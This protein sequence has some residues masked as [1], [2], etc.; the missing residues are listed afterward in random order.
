MKRC[1]PREWWSA[2]A[3]SGKHDTE[4]FGFINSKSLSPGVEQRSRCSA[5]RVR[6]VMVKTVLCYRL[7][8]CK[9]Q[10]GKEMQRRVEPTA[11]GIRH[12]RKDAVMQEK[13]S[14]TR[15]SHEE[16]K[17]SSSR[18]RRDC[19][20]L[21]LLGLLCRL[22]RRIGSLSIAGVSDGST[23]VGLGHSI[24]WA[25]RWSGSRAGLLLT[26]RGLAILAAEVAA[27][28]DAGADPDTSD[29]DNQNNEHDDPLPM[30]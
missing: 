18:S 29:G 5:L 25:P 13:T 17:T 21:L 23:R 6:L 7:R 1:R 19:P 22:K 4:L 20:L 26:E 8:R 12:G 16:V 2:S 14:Q 27:A 28:P 9:K 3:S 30:V 11:V 24:A 10:G 15:Y